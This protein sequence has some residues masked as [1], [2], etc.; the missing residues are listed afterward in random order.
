MAK[1]PS[2]RPRTAKAKAKPAKNGYAQAKKVASKLGGGSGKAVSAIAK[3]RKARQ[4]ALK[5]LG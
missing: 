4:K 2:S 1:K 3:A 5:E